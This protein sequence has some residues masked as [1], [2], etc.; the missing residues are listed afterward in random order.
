MYKEYYSP[1]LFEPT[2]VTRS[3]LASFHLEYYKD[4]E[5][6]FSGIPPELTVSLENEKNH[7]RPKLTIRGVIMCFFFT[8]M[9][10][11]SET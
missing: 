4:L 7:R 1:G 6:V 3:K 10:T 8:F 9:R 5:K 11:C 2:T